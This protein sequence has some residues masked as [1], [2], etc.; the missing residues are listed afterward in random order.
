MAI[1]IIV[2]VDIIEM[3]MIMWWCVDDGFTV[4]G[5]NGDIDIGISSIDT[6]VVYD[7]DNVY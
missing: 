1:I 6:M 7:N 3:M 2:I 4:I 5:I